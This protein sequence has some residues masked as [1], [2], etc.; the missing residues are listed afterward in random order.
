MMQ[1]MMAR[2]EGGGGNGPPGS[3]GGGHTGGEND[4]RF[5]TSGKTA[6]DEEWRVVRS[7]FEKQLGAKFDPQYPPKYRRLL[8]A[9]YER[10][11]SEPPR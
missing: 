10:L 5:P 4:E 2:G 1:M 8:D 11:R 6:T 7:R 3:K 9:Y